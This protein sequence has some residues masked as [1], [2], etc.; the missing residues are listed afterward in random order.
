MLRAYFKQQ[1]EDKITQEC[2]FKPKINAKSQCRFYFYE[3][4]TD[5][6]NIKQKADVIKRNELWKQCKEKKLEQLKRE[7]D[8]NVMDD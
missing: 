6:S 4:T 1:E 3:S 2:T 8:D 7:R 5:T